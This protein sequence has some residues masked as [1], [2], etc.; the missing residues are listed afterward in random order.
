VNQNA[1]QVGYLFK[2]WIFMPK[3]ECR[4]VLLVKNCH[5]N[6]Q[7]LWDKLSGLNVHVCIFYMYIVGQLGVENDIIAL[8]IAKWASCVKNATISFTF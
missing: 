4:V 3:L 1:G 5:K 8:L 2:E 7:K 6:G